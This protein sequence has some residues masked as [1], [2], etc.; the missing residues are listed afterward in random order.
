MAGAS[1]FAAITDWLHDLDEHARTRLGF[2]DDV[3]AGTTIWRLLIRLDAGLLAAVLAGWLH[4]RTSQPIPPAPRRSRRVIAVD[5]KTLRGA[6]LDGGRQ[7]HLLSVNNPKVHLASF[8]SSG[9][10]REWRWR[11]SLG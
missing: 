3:P 4:A 6:R 8:C 10:V 7:V 11:A 9:C 1:S 2:T 5:G